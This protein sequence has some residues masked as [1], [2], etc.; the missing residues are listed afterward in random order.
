[1]PIPQHIV[2][3]NTGLLRP[4]PLEFDDF[5]NHTQ[6]FVVG[7]TYTLQGK[8][9]DGFEMPTRT[10]V[11]KG[12]LD[13]LYGSEINAVIMKQ[14][15]GDEDYIFSLTRL[16]CELFGIE[17]ESKLQLFPMSFDWKSSNHRTF[18]NF[19]ANNLGTYR[20]HQIEN[21]ISQMHV[22]LYSI[23][24]YRRGYIMTPN[25]V[26]M[27]I[28]AFLHNLQFFFKEEPLSRISITHRPLALNEQGTVL[29]NESGNNINLMLFFNR[30]IDPEI[31][32]GKNI[33]QVIGARW[34]EPIDPNWE[35]HHNQVGGITVCV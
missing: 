11:C 14:I 13:T 15:D 35:Y 17:F 1:M 18:R 3:L 30:S 33:D 5:S 12:V 26:P 34:S 24:P 20:P 31:L 9:C 4:I 32:E 10:Y 29:I 27:P 28:E 16:D 7:E 2:S 6:R 8:S 23:R 21:K 22:T 19:D 25:G